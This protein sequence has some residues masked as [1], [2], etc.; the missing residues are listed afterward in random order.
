MFCTLKQNLY[1]FWKNILPF[2]ILFWTQFDTS[3]FLE[4]LFLLFWWWIT[5]QQHTLFSSVGR[6]LFYFHSAFRF[7]PHFRSWPI[8]SLYQSRPTIELFPITF[9]SDGTCIWAIFV[10]FD[11]SNQ[12]NSK[13]SLNGALSRVVHKSTGIT[14]LITPHDPPTITLT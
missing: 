7:F 4:R 11:K 8:F 14:W 5:S 12:L 13:T 1:I 9:L 3:L 6:S 10:R 2:S